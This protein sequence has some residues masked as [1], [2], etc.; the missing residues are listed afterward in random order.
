MEKEKEKENL[1]KKDARL[2]K[3]NE[4]KKYKIAGIILLGCLFLIFLS[5]VSK[6]WKA[7]HDIVFLQKTKSLIQRAAKSSTMAQQD[8]NPI[9]GLYHASEGVAYLQAARLL[10]PPSKLEKLINVD[11]SQLEENLNMQQKLAVKTI[12]EYCPKVKPTSRNV[13]TWVE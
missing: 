12:Y 11:V 3:K 6:S 2:E 13:A 10:L 1:E 4:G 7:D 8:S 5:K 9:I